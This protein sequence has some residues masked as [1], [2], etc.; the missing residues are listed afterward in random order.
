LDALKVVSELPK[1]FSNKPRSNRR[2]LTNAFKEDIVSPE[3]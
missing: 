1:I 3:F 2:E